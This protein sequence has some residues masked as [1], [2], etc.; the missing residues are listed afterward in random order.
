MLK[1]YATY[2][3]PLGRRSA[4]GAAAVLLALGMAGS[5]CQTT[6]RSGA[7]VPAAAAPVHPAA[8]HNPAPP[9][10]RP[11]DFAAALATLFRED[12]A[13]Q[14]QTVDDLLHNVN[15]NTVDR[16]Q[17]LRVI[18][19]A[20]ANVA[21]QIQ[22]LLAAKDPET[23]ARVQRLLAFQ[24][25]IAAF[26]VAALDA[27]PELRAQIL[28]WGLTVTPV[29]TRTRTSA[30]GS[31]GGNTA[32]GTVIPA[33]LAGQAFSVNPTDRAL[34][35]AT[36]AEVS[37][38]ASDWLLGRLIDDPK[39]EVSLA[40]INASWNRPLTAPLVDSLWM[41]AVGYPLQ[42][43]GIRADLLPDGMRILPPQP[44]GNKQVK[45]GNR[46]VIVYIDN[47]A[48]AQQAQ[49]CDMATDLLMAGRNSL[50]EKRLTALLTTLSTPNPGGNMQNVQNMLLMPG[51]GGAGQNMQRLLTEIK[52]RAAVKA[53]VQIAISSNTN[54]NAWENNMAGQITRCSNRIDALGMLVTIID[55]DKDEYKLIKSPMYNNR[56]AL[57][58]T[59][60]DEEA[61][62]SKLKAWWQIHRGEYETPK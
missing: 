14:S 58:G 43:N 6:P 8:V 7:P 51:Y 19:Q 55:L 61:A 5:G 22:I 44:Q 27:P 40:A 13:L 3:T 50:V 60:D 25:G 17:M 54:M 41:K 30:A 46:T 62:V 4:C 1:C 38:D 42:Q 35:A 2:F 10:T 24:S 48:I 59:K 53:L 31:L 21:A 45:V 28:Q 15:R 9:T 52:P 37:G 34:A 36:L 39:R 16:D 33:V 49:D 47:N 18:K 56:W 12:D 23:Q 32:T 11:A 26:S 29:P 57:T 20:Q